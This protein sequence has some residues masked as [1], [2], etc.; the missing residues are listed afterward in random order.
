MV[1]LGDTRKVQ[2]A[3]VGTARS[4]EP[5][6][7]PEVRFE[8]IRFRAQYAH[9]S[10]WCGV[11]LGGCGRK[12]STR[13]GKVRIPHFAHY[14]ERHVCRRRYTDITSADHLYLTRDLEH[15]LLAQGQGTPEVDLRG[16]FAE[17]DTCRQAVLTTKQGHVSVEFKPG[18]PQEEGDHAWR[19]R[20]FGPRAIPP[21]RTVQEQRYVLRARLGE[22]KGRYRTEIGTMTPKG[23][24]LWTP[25]RECVLTERGLTTP[26][27]PALEPTAEGQARAAE[28]FG[29]P[30]DHR[31]LIA[32]PKGDRSSGRHGANSPK[33]PHRLAVYFQARQQE[34]RA[35]HLWLPEPVSGLAAGEPHR[36][37]GPAWADL[38]RSAPQQW[39]VRAQGLAPVESKPP[40]PKPV[41]ASLK[42]ASPKPEPVPKPSVP[43]PP[44]PK[45][46]ARPAPPVPDRSRVPGA[47]D[48]GPG[49]GKLKYLPNGLL[50]HSSPPPGIL[51]WLSKNGWSGEKRSRNRRWIAFAMTDENR[52][53]QTQGPQAPHVRTLVVL[54]RLGERWLAAC[55][56][57]SFNRDF[58]ATQGCFK[59]E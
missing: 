27:M 7:M 35:G 42:P 52:L 8:A 4:R 56:L 45:P 34:R 20:L 58:I 38:D 14:P 54:R 26:H 2:T 25:L 43:T 39:S 15:W 10:F 9:R 18:V 3:V 21:P 36:I 22:T 47:T 30:L 46:E 50:E 57:D 5:V 44:K 12:L 55:L 51:D 41:P 32:Y 13:V 1:V 29:L 48:D 24:T 23:E 49:K 31:D 6:Q 33:H 40:E 59:V 37:S 11:W 19:T 17:G 28:V 53:R 16:D